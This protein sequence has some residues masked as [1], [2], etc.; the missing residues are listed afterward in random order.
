VNPKELCPRCEHE[1]GQHSAVLAGCGA[2]VSEENG[3]AIFCSCE[4]FPTDLE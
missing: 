4:R 2:I 3:G 1:M